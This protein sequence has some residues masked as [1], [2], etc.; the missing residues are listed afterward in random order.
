M[1]ELAVVG[2]LADAEVHVALRRHVAEAMRDDL[3]DHRD[4]ALDLPGDARPHVRE[5]EAEEL[6]LRLP[7][8]DV[9]P[10]EVHGVD[11]ALARALDELVVDVG[12]VRDERDVVTAGGVALPS[13]VPHEHV[14]DHQ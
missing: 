4:D 8:R 2:L 3:L 1:A 7:L 12:V 9:R 5:R 6:L 13:E 10:R 14:V 11:A